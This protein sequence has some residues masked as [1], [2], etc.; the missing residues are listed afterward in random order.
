MSRFYFAFQCKFPNG[1]ECAAVDY[2]SDSVNL[3][4]AVSTFGG[5]Y[6]PECGGRSK[7]I[8]IQLCKTKREAKETASAWNQLIK[9]RG[10]HAF[11]R[12]KLNESN[13]TK[14]A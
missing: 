4:R 14:G 6:L 8:T 7:V 10:V 12:N 13:Q 11:A 5:I 2:F 3:F 9:A 1:T